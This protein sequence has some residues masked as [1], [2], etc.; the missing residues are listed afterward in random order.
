MTSTE[1][2]LGLPPNF[3]KAV[4][5]GD[6]FIRDVCETCGFIAYQNPKVVVGAV[7]HHEGKVLLCRRAIEPRAGLWTVPAGYLELGET[8]AEGAVREAQEEAGAAIVIEN[9]LAIYTIPHVAQVHIMHVARLDP[10]QVHAGPES[11]E[12]KLF[13]WGQLPWSELAF[14]SVR[15]ALTHFKMVQDQETFPVFTSPSPD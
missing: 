3:A 11:L 13:E 15:W 10:P 5:D 12:V 4:P 6:T 1:R 14:P 2:E 7:V 9:V 8:I